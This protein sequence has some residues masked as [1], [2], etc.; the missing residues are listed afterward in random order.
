[1]FFYDNEYTEADWRHEADAQELAMLDADA[2]DMQEYPAPLSAMES[3]ESKRY[4]AWGP[5]FADDA[6]PIGIN[7]AI[8]APKMQHKEAA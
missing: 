1:M 3:A 6:G 2:R 4:L 5:D 8:P 7:G